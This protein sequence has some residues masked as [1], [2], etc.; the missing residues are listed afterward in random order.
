MSLVV[1]F[2]TPIT[3]FISGLNAEGA[4]SDLKDLAAGSLGLSSS[5]ETVFTVVLDPATDKFVVNQVAAG[6]ADLVASG[7]NSAGVAVSGKG[8]ITLNPVAPPPPPPPPP[9]TVV[10]SLVVNF[11]QASA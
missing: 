10:A 9:D 7:I 5:D 4:A 1:D 2:G 6:T 3:G 8:T 11:D